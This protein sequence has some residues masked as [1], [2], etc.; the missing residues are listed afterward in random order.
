MVL[1]IPHEK[2]LRKIIV[3]PYAPLFE[4]IHDFQVSQ[5][6]SWKFVSVDRAAGARYVVPGTH[7]AKKHP[8]RVLVS[9]ALKAL[10]QSRLENISIIANSIDAATKE[11]AVP[12]D[13]WQ[14]PEFHAD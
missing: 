9:F 13:F 6:F 8:L 5:A 2:N 14:V 10:A 1:G 4:Q 12:I 11:P 3:Q 7:F